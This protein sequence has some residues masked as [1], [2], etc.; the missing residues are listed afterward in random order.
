VPRSK[1]RVW[2]MEG[3]WSP[4]VPDVRTVT[5]ILD[6]LHNSGT[7]EYVLQPVNSPEDLAASLRRWGQRQHDTFNIGYL[8][9]HGSPQKVYVGRRPVSISDLGLWADG[10]LTRRSY[11]SILFGTSDQSKR[12]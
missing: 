10:R 3:N 11:I 7:V 4:S 9:L 8:A 2:C 5:Q 12:A 6:A 1:P